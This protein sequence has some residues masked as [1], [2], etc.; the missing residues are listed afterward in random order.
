MPL[1]TLGKIF[2][3]DWR[4][5]GMLNDEKKSPSGFRLPITMIF[6]RFYE[7]PIRETFL[8]VQKGGCLPDCTGKRKGG[9]IFLSSFYI[10]FS[11]S[12]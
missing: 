8:E 4:L 7:L 11:V 2:E 10:I 5:F 1:N 3:L 12:A 9:R 6:L